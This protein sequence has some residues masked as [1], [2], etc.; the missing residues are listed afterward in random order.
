MCVIS[1]ANLI[2]KPENLFAEL[3]NICLKIS[4]ALGAKIFFNSVQAEKKH[5]AQ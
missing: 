4:K 5:F 2:F 1:C 3:K